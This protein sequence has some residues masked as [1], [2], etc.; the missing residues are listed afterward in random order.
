MGA[1]IDLSGTP[2]ASAPRS[3]RSVASSSLMKA[4]LAQVMGFIPRLGRR[5]TADG[6]IAPQRSSS[7]LPSS[8]LA[9]EGYSPWGSEYSAST[10]PPPMYSSTSALGLGPEGS[11]S[12]TR[13]AGAF[14]PPPLRR[15]TSTP[16]K[17]RSNS[18]MQEAQDEGASSQLRT[19]TNAGG[20]RPP[21]R[22]QTLGT[23]RT[24]DGGRKD[25]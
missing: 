4:V 11:G 16:P 9:T 19:P 17:S 5:R 21:M 25:D 7:P 10:P 6:L 13:G 14:T 8:T 15:P 2:Q 24:D 22:R 12:G 1:T 20:R 23:D 3:R 18:V